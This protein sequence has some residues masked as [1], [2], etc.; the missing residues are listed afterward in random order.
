MRFQVFKTAIT[1]LFFDFR[2]T[3]NPPLKKD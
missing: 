1:R 2:P 3:T